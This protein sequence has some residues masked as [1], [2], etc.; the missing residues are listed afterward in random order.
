[1]FIILG[2]NQSQA[3][4]NALSIKFVD[5]GLNETLIKRI[6]VLLVIKSYTKDVGLSP[7]S[8]K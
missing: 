7:Y 1:M 6:L 3:R 8:S 4:M 5:Q 2:I